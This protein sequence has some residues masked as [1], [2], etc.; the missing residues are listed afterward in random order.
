MK[1]IIV[2]TLLFSS[3]QSYSLNLFCPDFM[4]GGLVIADLSINSPSVDVQNYIAPH[5]KIEAT[6]TG[7]CK[8]KNSKDFM[9][10]QEGQFMLNIPISL[11]A[12]ETNRGSVWINDDTDDRTEN[13]S[14]GDQ[15]ECQVF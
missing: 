3:L 5:W 6:A 13:G 9:C 7:D 10:F 8:T 14:L 1:S 12:G 15:Y 2:L 11:A 4:K